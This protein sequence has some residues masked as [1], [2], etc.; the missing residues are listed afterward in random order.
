MTG[1]G[2]GCP[3]A[4]CSVS[5]PAKACCAVAGF[6]PSACALC[7]LLSAC[8][9]AQ[10]PRLAFPFLNSRS[11]TSFRFAS[12]P[13]SHT[14]LLSSPHEPFEFMIC[15]YTL[16]L[17]TPRPVHP[18]LVLSPS[19]S[20]RFRFLPR[21]LTPRQTQLPLYDHNRINSVVAGLSRKHL[22]TGKPL[23]QLLVP[24]A[25]PPSSSAKHS[26]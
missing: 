10:V 3:L 18:T 15:S 22:H 21:G 6:F 5:L 9:W 26:C 19:P 7:T 1:A 12:P 11:F 14:L 4:R 25:D 23:L 8:T 2:P 16:P 17:F 24:L 20:S 13:V